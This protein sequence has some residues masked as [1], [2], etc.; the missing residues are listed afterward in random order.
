MKIT[1]SVLIVENHKTNFAQYFDVTANVTEDSVEV[2]D[3]TAVNTIEGK[4]T[5]STNLTDFFN[6]LSGFNMFKYYE[7]EIDWMLLYN[8]YLYDLTHGD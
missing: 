7:K 8:E 1:Y 6:E 3:I 5:H 4:E 2:I